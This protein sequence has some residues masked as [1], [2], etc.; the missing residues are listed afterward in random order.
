[1]VVMSG[2]VVQRAMTGFERESVAAIVVDL[3]CG[4]RRHVRHRP[5]LEDHAWVADD[6]LA[7][8]RVGQSIECGRCARLEPPAKLEVYRTTATFAAA[9]IPAGLRR[10]HKTKTGVWG[11]LVV[12]QGWAELRFGSLDNRCARAEAGESASIPPDLAHVLVTSDN[13]R[14]YIE[15]ARPL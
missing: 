10:E 9:E 3:D 14:L 15:F 12:V 4:H 8:A 6:A 7:K 5:P 1:M 2:A 11:R 13:V